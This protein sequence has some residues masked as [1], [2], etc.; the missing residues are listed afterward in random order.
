MSSKADVPKAP[1]APYPG[2]IDSTFV[3][4]WWEPLMPFEC[5]GAP[6]VHYTLQHKKE[7]T[8][9]EDVY[10]GLETNIVVD[11]LEPGQLYLFRIRATNS[12][13]DS[14]FSPTSVIRMSTREKPGTMKLPECAEKLR[15]GANHW[16]EF[17]DPRGE[18]V[19]YFNKLTGNVSPT[20]PPDFDPQRRGLQPESVRF[21]KKRQK[22]LQQV[23]VGRP[24][25]THKFE[26]ARATVLNDTFKHMAKMGEEVLKLRFQVEYKGEAGIDSGGLVKDWFLHVSRALV[27][28]EEGLFCKTDD[29]AHVQFN[30]NHFKE[31]HLSW[32]KFAGKLVGKAIYDRHTVDVRFNEII[33]K[34][35]LK[36]E[37]DFADMKRI[38]PVFCKSLEWMQ[39]H[40]IT[41]VIFETFSVEEKHQGKVQVVDLIENGREVQVTE[42]NKQ[43]FIK[44]MVAWRTEFAVSK[45]LQAFLKGVEVLVPLPLLQVF[46]LKELVR[47]CPHACV[48]CLFAPPCALR[49]C[50]N[51]SLR[52]C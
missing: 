5:N 42:A 40:D 47:A 52:V 51:G 38:D 15:S 46:S 10:Q 1:R 27:A 20:Q 4:M 41:D 29:K 8:E 2:V 33:Y 28:T 31:N 32:F 49:W 21:R 7:G 26:V 19:F 25:G 50:V 14:E 16:S 6:V 3:P 39:T 36:K 24:T 37:I 45:S 18:K 34:H 30:N 13:G 35:L 9:F 48:Y 23:H 17:W 43:E 12:M 44:L 11:D 22:F